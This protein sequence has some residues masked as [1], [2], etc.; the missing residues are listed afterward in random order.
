MLSHKRKSTG[1]SIDFQCPFGDCGKTFEDNYSLKNHTKL[2]K[3][4]LDSCFFCPWK[5]LMHTTHYRVHIYQH[6][7]KIGDFKCSYC[8]KTFFTRRQKTDHEETHEKDFNKYKCKFCSFKTHSSSSFSHHKCEL[9]IKNTFW[10]TKKHVKHHE[11]KTVGGRIDFMCDRGNCGK[12]FSNDHHLKRHQ[13]LHDNNLVH[14]YLCPWKTPVGQNSHISTHYDQHFN[15][16]N[17]KC[18]ICD[19]TFYRRI[20]LNYHFEIYHEKI[21]GKYACKHCPYRT[22]S[23]DCLFKHTSRFHKKFSNRR[24]NVY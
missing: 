3:N 24:N 12:T 5:G 20:L 17:F 9:K 2:H 21:E 18:S 8:S 6:L 15:R 7:T 16:A 1:G 13:N 14:C 23:K 10:A 11:R 22:H 4:H 19:K